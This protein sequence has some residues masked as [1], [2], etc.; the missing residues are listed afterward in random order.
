LLVNFDLPWNPMLLEQRIGRI[1]R[2]GQAHERITVCNFVYQNSVE[3]IVYIRLV[4]RFQDAVSVTG[5]LQFSLL[6]IEEKDFQDYA[7]TRG[8]EGK[9]DWDT[10]LQ[11][12][13]VHRQRMDERRRLTEFAAEQQKTAYEMLEREAAAQPPPVTLDEIW[14]ALR[15]SPT[16]RSLGCAVE[17][18]EYGEALSL[19]GLLEVAENCLLTASP[20]LYEHGL[21]E[22]DGRV[23]RFATYG[24][25]AFDA[26]LD[27]MLAGEE[28]VQ[29]AWAERTP[30][31]YLVTET[32]RIDR[33][34]HKEDRQAVAKVPITV[35]AR[36]PEPAQAETRGESGRR[37][38]ALVA[39]AAAALARMKLPDRP[40]P[41]AR[42]MQRLDDFIRRRP[43]PL[44]Q[45]PVALQDQSDF[46]AYSD[47]LLWPVTHAGTRLT[48][49]PILFE[50]CRDMIE[51]AISAL[52][53]D[54]RTNEAI[55]GH[56][57][58]T[59]KAQ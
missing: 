3:E 52:S 27:Y 33:F 4:R 35:S 54:R 32:S 12:A 44:Y 7:K 5:A 23:L 47:Q 43:Q 6:P 39:A 1:D 22:G 17:T 59:R 13:E 28:Y 14:H 42:H 41:P 34:P 49:D 19:C 56:I 51:R 38:Q 25:S 18:F 36:A 50:V 8:E 15:E 16:L 53:S 31:A 57:E 30:L 46:V 26:V 48:G 58:R 29:Q 24:D 21:P 2:I 45:L 9:I 10:L 40:A 55:A 20:R 11:R 37:H